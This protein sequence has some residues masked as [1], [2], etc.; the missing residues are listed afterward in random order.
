MPSKI[1]Q[2]WLKQYFELYKKPLFGESVF[3][4]LLELKQCL[5]ETHKSGKK[6]H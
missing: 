5:E 3:I 1:N 6:I 4:Q 2:S